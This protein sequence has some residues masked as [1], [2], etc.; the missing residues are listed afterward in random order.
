VRS[1]HVAGVLALAVWALLAGGAASAHAM[2]LTD[3]SYYWNTTNTESAE[4]AGCLQG[5]ADALG[6]TS[7]EVILDFGGQFSDYSGTES[8]SDA[9]EFTNS[10]IE[11]ISLSFAR[12]YYICTGEDTTTTLILGGGTN[13]SKDAIS[14]SGGEAWAKVADAVASAVLEDPGE[15]K[16]VV[17]WGADDLEVGYSTGGAASNW[18]TGFLERTL[19]ERSELLYL[20]YGG[21]EGCPTSTH[22][23]GDCTGGESGWDQDREYLV[24][25]GIDGAPVP[26]IYYN[27]PPGSPVNAEQWAEVAEYSLE[28]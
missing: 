22:D 18:A 4:E 27:R 7:S 23:N 25:Y 12:G 24:S 10:E 19:L 14:K 17:I 28:I 26:E 9:L 13:N 3:Q 11:N 21:A 15:A 20:D 6:E 16:Q 8:T 5:L 1:R 2:P